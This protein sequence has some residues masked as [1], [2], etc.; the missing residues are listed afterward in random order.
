VEIDESTAAT[1]ELSLHLASE[2]PEVTVETE[3]PAS[4]LQITT[5]ATG[6]LSPNQITN[7]PDDNLWF[8]AYDPSLSAYVA[9]K[10]TTGGSVTTYPLA[11]STYIN[12]IDP[13]TDRLWT[14]AGNKV[15]R[16]SLSGVFAYVYYGATTDYY[17]GSA[18]G[19]DGNQWLPNFNGGNVLMLT[20]GG[21]ATQYPLVTSNA[22]PADIVV[23]P[24]GKLWVSEYLVNKIARITTGGVVAEFTI[25]TPNFYPLNM[26]AG[27]DGNV[28]FSGDST[29]GVGRITSGG[30]IKVFPVPVG[31]YP[32]QLVVG[33]DGNF[34][35]PNWGAP[36]FVR[37]TT[38]GQVTVFNLE[39]GNYVNDI[40]AGSDGNIW[41]TAYPNAI[42]K[43]NPSNAN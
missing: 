18:L 10:V 9:G 34:W 25:P 31:V 37:V 27:P 3:F 4:G 16:L 11:A 21:S 8:S 42:S 36:G 7:G 28:W 20:P 12:N 5:Y 32:G 35:A 29:L 39:P 26:V 17:Y 43:F 2:G 6:S 38:S 40:A 15:G 24:D 30:T 14:T 1:I 41:F 13:G 19:P 23:G 22:G 33:A